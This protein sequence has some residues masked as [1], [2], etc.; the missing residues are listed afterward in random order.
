M[1]FSHVAYYLF[2]KKKLKFMK[3]LI[4]I[5]SC[6]LLLIVVGE[7]HAQESFDKVLMNSGEQKT[8]KVMAI[9]EESIKFVHRNETLTYTIAKKD[10]NKIEFASGRIEVITP[11]NMVSEDQA[12]QLQAHHNVIAILPFAFASNVGGNLPDK[13]NTKVQS[14]CARLLR[15]STRQFTVQDPINT[16]AILGKHKINSDNVTSYTPE[17]IAHILNVEYVIYGSVTVTQTGAT[18]TGGDYFNAKDKGR[19]V[20]GYNLSTTSS[21]SQFSTDV[22]MNVYNETGEN[23]FSRSHESFWQTNDAYEITLQWL[24]KRSPF[25]S[26]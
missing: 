3:H 17:E 8:G 11:V 22:E 7:S 26:K 9:D 6:L 16:N 5:S 14:D 1:L 19:K 18:T 4:L 24:L 2:R 12:G 13:M 20:S 25:Y 21:T 23:I 15:K 10:I